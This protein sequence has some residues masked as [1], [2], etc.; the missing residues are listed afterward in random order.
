MRATQPPNETRDR[1]VRLEAMRY[2]VGGG[3]R[4]FVP[5]V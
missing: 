1:S 4:G 5:A 3:Q 2:E